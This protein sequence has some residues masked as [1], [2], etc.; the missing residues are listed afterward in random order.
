M[1][2]RRWRATGIRPMLQQNWFDVGM[3]GEQT[4]QFRSAVSREPDDAYPE[5]II[6][7]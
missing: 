2:Y 1:A 7:H 6:I 5:R 4:H 3:L